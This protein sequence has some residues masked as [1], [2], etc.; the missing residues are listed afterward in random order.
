MGK[1][2]NTNP[3]ADKLAAE[4]EAAEEDAKKE[5]TEREAA[6]KEAAKKTGKKVTW[7]DGHTRCPRCGAADTEAYSTRKNIQ[8]RRCSRAICRHKYTVRGKKPKSGTKV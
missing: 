8:Y 7:P 5:Y 4:K 1:N 6:E 2:E 3:A